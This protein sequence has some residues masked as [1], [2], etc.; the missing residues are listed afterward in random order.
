MLLKT[1][2]V[3]RGW[4]QSCQA[5]LCSGHMHSNGNTWQGMAAEL[6]SLCVIAAAWITVTVVF[7][8]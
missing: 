2:L 4:Q 3:S 6:L 7:T 1:I 8:S 5:V